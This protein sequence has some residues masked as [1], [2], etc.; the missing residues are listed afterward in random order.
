MIID[1]DLGD[2]VEESINRFTL[3]LCE[4]VCEDLVQQS[5]VFLTPE[6]KEYMDIDQ[7]K[8]Y[9]SLGATQMVK[10]LMDKRLIDV[11]ELMK[12]VKQ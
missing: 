12:Y 7:F 9:A 6:Q 5:A 8:I 4:E 1:E 2:D 3:M 11:D 10:N